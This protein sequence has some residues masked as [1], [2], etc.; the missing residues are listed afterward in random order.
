MARL[1]RFDLD[2]RLAN[3]T[4]EIG[5]SGQLDG[6]DVLFNCVV[7]DAKTVLRNA[8]ASYLAA[9]RAG[10]KRLVYLSSAVVHAQNPAQGT[11]DESR[12]IG[13]QPFKYNV[14][15]VLAEKALRRLRRDGAPEV[16]VLRPSIV[17]GP[18]SLWWTSRIA[19]DIVSGRAY[20]V[21]DGAGVCNTVYVDNLVQAMWLAAVAPQ[22]ANQDFLVT[23][24]I[25]ISWR[26]LY[27][28][29]ARAVG[30][31]GASI[32]CVPRDEARTFLSREKRKRRLETLHQIARAGSMV[33]GHLVPETTKERLS[34]RLQSAIQSAEV[35]FPLR[36]ELVSL[37]M[38]QYQLPIA[39]AERVLGYRPAVGFDEACRRTEAWLQFSMGR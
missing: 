1:A 19:S 18:R 37:Q 28:S 13:R 5:L 27:E 11:D 8:T 32:P 21:D 26:K 2:C 7:G 9:R 34:S 16:V 3:A 4:E 22:A 36:S 10:V 14:S 29:L 25:R 12:L 31:D 35:P 6:C 15:K 38:C 23:D 39:K 20:L 30:T 33:M 17:F 24:G